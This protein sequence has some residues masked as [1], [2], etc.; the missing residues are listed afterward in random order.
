[1]RSGEPLP[2]VR[3]RTDR[4]LHDDI[5][6]AIRARAKAHE[7]GRSYLQGPWLREITRRRNGPSFTRSCNR[8]NNRLLRVCEC[9]YERFPRAR[10]TSE[11]EGLCNL[12]LGLCV[13]RTLREELITI[14]LKTESRENKASSLEKLIISLLL[15]LLLFL[16]DF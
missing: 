3:H 4:G 12:Y 7:N 13:T 14:R 16:R 1:M 9:V 8:T 10:H 15:S 11:E 5:P 6:S 2:H